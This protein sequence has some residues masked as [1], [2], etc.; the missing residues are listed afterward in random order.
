MSKVCEYCGDEARH[1]LA[2]EIRDGLKAR[3]LWSPHNSADLIT[4]IFSAID[5]NC[6][7]RTSDVGCNRHE[8]KE[9]E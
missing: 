1:S 3:G 6:K 7:L 9:G 5:H 8:P 2:Q 4:A